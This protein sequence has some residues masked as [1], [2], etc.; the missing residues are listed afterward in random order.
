MLNNLLIVTGNVVS[1]PVSRTTGSG[2][3]VTN[4]RVASNEK[5]FNSE[6]QQYETTSTSFYNVSCWQKLGERV[7][8][9]IRKGDAVLVVGRPQVREFQRQAGH[10]D[11]SVDINAD[12]FGPDMRRVSLTVERKERAA[13]STSPESI[14]PD[15]WTSTSMPTETR[16]VEEP[17]A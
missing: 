8:S 16:Q 4:V 3:V 13:V 11:H 17:A 5:R 7:A 9:S 1:D 14:A 6:T 2:R 10:L 12:H 15:P